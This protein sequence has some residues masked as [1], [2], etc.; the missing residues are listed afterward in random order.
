MKA[1][2]IN[3]TDQTITTVEYFNLSDLQRMV[4]GYIE[5]IHCWD[6]G[7]VIFGDEEGLLKGLTTW[8]R[9]EGYDRPFAGNAVVVG[10]E[11]ED[12]S[13]TADPTITLDQLTAI[14]TF[15]TD[16]QA[17]AWARGNASDPA[18]MFFSDHGRAETIA[19]T[20]ELFGVA[21]KHKPKE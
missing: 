8:F 15:I 11:D 6:N 20:G 18:I 2:W 13:A 16:E 4:G 9:L 21:P 3:A 7:D 17:L 14:V 19:S 5:I 10:A 1:Y 12:D